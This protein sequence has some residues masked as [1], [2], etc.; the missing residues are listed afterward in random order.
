[1]N[2]KKK[3]EPIFRFPCI[4]SWES[5]PKLWL[6]ESIQMTKSLPQVANYNVKG[7]KWYI[8]IAYIFI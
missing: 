6:F 5:N 1:M 2:L 7:I 8:L 3:K 4:G